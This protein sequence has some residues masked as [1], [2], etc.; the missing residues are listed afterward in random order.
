MGQLNH[1]VPPTNLMRWYSNL[2]KGNKTEAVRAIYTRA[3]VS[4][5]YATKWVKGLRIPTKEHHL[6]ALAEVTGIAKDELFKPAE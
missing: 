2:E 4:D 1:V 5:V 3:G 6:V